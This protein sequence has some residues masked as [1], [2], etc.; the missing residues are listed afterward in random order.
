MH[1]RCGKPAF[2]AFLEWFHASSGVASRRMR[3]TCN[4]FG[5][6]KRAR[7]RQCIGGTCKPI[8]QD[9]KWVRKAYLIFLNRSIAFSLVLRKGNTHVLHLSRT[10]VRAKCAVSRT[11]R[12]PTQSART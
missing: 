9:A 2:M 4:K 10:V 3:T 5:S 1:E 11:M 7:K 12:S 6:K 8:I